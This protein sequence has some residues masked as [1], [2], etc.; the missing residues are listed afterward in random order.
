M[1]DV[2]Y[3]EKEDGTFPAEE[4]ILSLDSKMQ[5]KMF[6]E[7]DLL[8]TFGNQLREPHSKPLGDGIYEIR[9]KVASDITRVLYFFV[10]NKKIILTNGFIKKTQK[11]P[12][13]EIAL[14]KKYRK[15]YLERN[16]E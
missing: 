3:Y 9:A 12:D 1:F 11:T 10:V 8:E 7:L 14:A 2:E 5:A 16:K 6:R 13:N 4:F 15:D